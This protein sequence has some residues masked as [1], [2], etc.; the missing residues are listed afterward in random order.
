MPHVRLDNVLMPEARKLTLQRPGEGAGRVGHGRPALRRARAAAGQGK[1]RRR[2][3]RR[4]RQ[5][6]PAAPDRL[7]DHDDESPEL[8]RRNQGRAARGPARRRGGRGRAP[9]GRRTR[10]SRSVTCVAPDGREQPLVR[11]RGR[12]EGDGRPARPLRDLERVERR[13]SATEDTSEAIA[14]RPKAEAAWP[15][16][17]PA[18]SPSLPATWPT[19]ARATCGRRRACPSAT[20]GLAGGLRASGRS[21]TICWP[22]PDAH[23]LGMVPLSAQVDRLMGST[24][25]T[26]SDGIELT[27]PVVAAGPARRCRSWSIS[28]AAAWSISPAGSGSSRSRCAA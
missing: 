4:P 10:Q 5:E 23:V 21:G 12:S 3:H 22:R 9:A 28:S 25:S 11:G 17:E 1:V 8:V 24:P 16:R 20:A 15:A 6:R 18:T 7:P 2:A 27:P 14:R 26:T 19:A 13:S